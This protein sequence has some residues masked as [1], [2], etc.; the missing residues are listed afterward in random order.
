[1]KPK[2]SY[3]IEEAQRVLE[4][5]CA[6]Q[7]RSYKEVEEK[8]YNMG[9]IQEVS[10]QILLS[11]MQNDF[12]NETRFAK[13]FAGGK[14]RIKKWGRLKIK[15]ALKQKGVSVRNIEIGLDEIDEISYIETIKTIIATR[16]IKIKA[17]NS[18]E[19][20]QKMLL[21]LQQRGFETDLIYDLVLHYSEN[22]KD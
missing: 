4:R 16:L 20:N 2:T 13:A 8:L 5:Y 11:L 12:I 7:E 10:N 15:Q 14:F 21:Y 3:T 1:M 19:R 18:Y 6:Y 17:K 9:M 22:Q